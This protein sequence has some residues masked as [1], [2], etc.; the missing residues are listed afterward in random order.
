[1]R[2]ALESP[3]TVTIKTLVFEGKGL[4]K[5]ADGKTA[6]VQ[7]ALPGETVDF[8]VL[9]KKRSFVQGWATDIQNPSPDRVK[10]TCPYFEICGGCSL[11]NLPY[12]K[13]LYW[14]NHFLTESIVRLGGF[15]AD[16][17]AQMQKDI[18]PAE[19]HFHYRNKTEFSFSDNEGELKLGFHNPLKRFYVLHH[20]QC[21]LHSESAQKAFSI[22]QEVCSK[23]KLDVFDLYENKK[24]FLYSLTF[25]TNADDQVLVIF[26]TNEAGFPDDEKKL[27]REAFQNGLGDKL[28]GICQVRK[29]RTET[30][31]PQSVHCLWGGDRLQD[32]VEDLSFEIGAVSF[33]QVNREMAGKMVQKLRDTVVDIAKD[34]DVLDLFCGNG[35]LGM[36]IAKEAKSVT[37]I[38][39]NT[40][41]VAEG[42]ENLKKNGIS[43]YTFYEGDARKTLNMLQEKGK[44]FDVVLVDPPRGGLGRRAVKTT[45]KCQTENVFYISCN[46]TTLARDLEYFEMCGYEVQSIQA[47]DLFPQTYHLETFCVLQ[48][49]KPYDVAKT[50]WIE[51]GKVWK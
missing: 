14:K 50:E 49:V 43:N 39:I 8:E 35:F 27:W 9:S 40:S 21:H 18:I 45:A 51:S 28:I 47:M 25:R 1:M 41:A 19:N 38:E 33:F 2:R 46:P 32:R 5:M 20:D 22:A 29:D 15:D 6:F 13:Q 48:K 34:G 26:N 11:Q 17:V 10:A 12:D 3:Q 23:S 30:G 44:T 37:G 36:A 16:R 31:S 4:G 24:G 42:K 7:K